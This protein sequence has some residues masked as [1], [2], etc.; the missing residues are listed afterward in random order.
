MF[1]DLERPVDDRAEPHA[2]QAH[3]RVAHGVAHVADL[4]RPP[5]VQRD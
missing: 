3:H 1:A 2:L 5:L 4:P